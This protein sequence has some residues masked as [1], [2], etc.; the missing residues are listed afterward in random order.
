MVQLLNFPGLKKRL[1]LEPR[2]GRAF[3]EMCERLGLV[4]DYVASVMS[5]ESAGT[6]DPAIKNPSGGAV[7]LIQFMPSTARA[8]GT[9]TEALAAM[10]GVEQLQYVERFFRGSVGKIRP[11]VPGDYYMSVFLPA[12]VGAPGDKV[13]GRKGDSSSLIGNLTLGAVYAQN[14][15]FDRQKRGF[16]TV[17]DVWDT[18]LSA[19][20]RARQSPA[21][22][23]EVDMTVPLVQ[24]SPSPPPLPLAAWRSSG[25]PSDLPVLRVG[26]EGTAVL[27]LCSLLGM[28]TISRVYTL[29]MAEAFVKPFQARSGIV[30]DGV[31]GMLTWEKLARSAK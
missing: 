24:A 2:F 12:F 21:G 8:L 22:P 19:L 6:F 1:E 16:F 9:T 4:P 26:A 7:G 20:N 15:G 18:T 11:D 23:L 27:L 10:S 5:V 14:A 30:A 29:A 28:R 17:Q 25:G 3:V 13:L 31:V